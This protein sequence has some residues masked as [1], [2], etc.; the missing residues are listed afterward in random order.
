[1]TPTITPDVSEQ[2]LVW[3]TSPDLG[4]GVD[5]GKSLRFVGLLHQS[6]RG[7]GLGNS[8]R[9]RTDNRGGNDPWLTTGWQN[10]VFKSTSNYQSIGR[11]HKSRLHQ[12]LSEGVWTSDAA[13]RGG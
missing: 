11:G 10:R 2:Q 5:G 12:E 1:M 7:P 13:L 4:N 3:E 6:R 9:C 8:E